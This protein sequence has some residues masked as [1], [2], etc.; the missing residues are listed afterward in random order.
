SG[1]VVSIEQ[2]IDQAIAAGQA[3]RL[4]EAE[5]LLRLA[6]A[7]EP[8]NPRAHLNL[9]VALEVQSQHGAAID[10][11]RRAIELRPDHAPSHRELAQC[12]MKLNRVSEAIAACREAPRPAPDEAESHGLLARLLLLSGDFKRGWAE[13]EWRSKCAPC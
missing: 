9:G 5:Q 11:I 3:G 12:L 6:V 1:P 13:Y 10:A 2:Q 4:A 8:L 7:A